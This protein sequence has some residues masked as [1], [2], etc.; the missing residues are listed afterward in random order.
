M[1]LVSGGKLLAASGVI[2]AVW[3]TGAIVGTNVVSATGDTTIQT[4]LSGNQQPILTVD[5][6]PQNKVL[7]AATPFRLRGSVNALAQ[8]R[9]YVDGVFSQ[10][11][12]LSVNDTSFDYDITVSPG[13][14]TVTVIGVSAY[15]STDQETNFTITY[16]PVLTPNPPPSNL[17][18]EGQQ[19]GVV[20][21]NQPQQGLGMTHTPL[22][23][24]VDALYNGF[25]ALNIVTPHDLTQTPAMLWRFTGV[26]TGLVFLLIPWAFRWL[27]RITW[28]KWLGYKRSLDVRHP[29]LIVRILGAVLLM[30]IIIA[31]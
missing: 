3:L 7:I 16:S 27:Y 17:Q 2:V 22:D 21:T 28:Y 13:T 8:L 31:G 25:V 10:V 6:V 11:V 24:M 26:T 23:P 29:L 5:N 4:V 14:H 30:L 9:I 1:R 18:G 19:G 20:L 12:P 15:T